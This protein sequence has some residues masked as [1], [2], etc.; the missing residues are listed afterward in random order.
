MAKHHGQIGHALL[1]VFVPVIKM[2]IGAADGGGVHLDQYLV[3]ADLG[4]GKILQIFCA[5]TGAHFADSSHGSRQR[6][7]LLAA[8]QR[9]LLPII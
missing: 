2:K 5:R 7:P 6:K 1:G 4:D 3:I 9:L 8:G